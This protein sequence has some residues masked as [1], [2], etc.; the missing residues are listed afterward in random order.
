MN[1]PT[2][3][4]LH[5]G[6]IVNVRGDIFFSETCPPIAEGLLLVTFQQALRALPFGWHWRDV[7]NDGVTILR[8]GEAIRARKT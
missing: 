6:D 8:G 1:T 7:D 3:A 2:S 4:Q 5:P